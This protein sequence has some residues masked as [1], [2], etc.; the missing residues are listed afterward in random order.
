MTPDTES[1]HLLYLLFL[2]QEQPR[3]SRAR[4]LAVADSADTEP[5]AHAIARDHC[6]RPLPKRGH[7]SQ[8]KQR[9]VAR[10]TP[11]SHSEHPVT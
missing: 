4:S 8:D 2:C 1:D 5:R 10:V 11:W 3:A 7:V 9:P 6:D